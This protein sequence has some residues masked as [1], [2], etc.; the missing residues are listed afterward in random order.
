[1]PN[2][3]LVPDPDRLQV[4][5]LRVRARDN[6]LGGTHARRNRRVPALR[7]TLIS[8]AFTVSSRAGK[9][10]VAGDSS[11]SPPVV[12][13]LLLRHVNL[14]HP[15][16]IFTERLPSLTAP[17]AHRTNRLQAWLRHIAFA[18]GGEP[19]A[20]LLRQLG[21][22]GCGDTL[23]A[24]MRAQPLPAQP[25]PRILSIDDFAFRRGRTYGSMLVDLERHEVV[26]LLRTGA[27][28]ALRR[29]SPLTLASRSSAATGAASTL[30]ALALARRRPVTWRTAFICSATCARWCCASSSA[31]PGWWGRWC[32][33]NQKRN[34]SR[35][36]AWIERE[37][38]SGREPRC[39]PGM[40]RSSS[41]HR[42]E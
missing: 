9:S 32:R 23:L 34:R 16:R 36:S 28:A 12:A 42:R 39:R 19:G 29:G 6:P 24:G 1:M 25:T 37:P 21:I 17:Y 8:G 33:R 31:M 18:L 30:R 40:R 14:R 5:C 11:S 4:L 15:R 22:T 10:P 7:P 27:A 3:S 20:R 13:A 2:Q 41:W 35:A 38:V 26:D